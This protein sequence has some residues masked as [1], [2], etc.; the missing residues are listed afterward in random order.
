MA[1]GSTLRIRYL[2]SL[3]RTGLLVATGAG[4]EQVPAAANSG[5]V[6][7][8]GVILFIFIWLFIYLFLCILRDYIIPF[9]TGVPPPG[10]RED[11]AVDTVDETSRIGEG[12]GNMVQTCGV[13]ALEA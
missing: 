1:A 11:E 7:L 3:E 8:R 4:A 10:S 6:I 12:R 5:K 2:H 13:C 9:L